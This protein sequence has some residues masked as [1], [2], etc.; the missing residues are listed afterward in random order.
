MPARERRAVLD[1]V[2]E[3][4]LDT[5]LVESL[6]VSIGSRWRCSTLARPELQYLA[7]VTVTHRSGFVIRTDHVEVALLQDLLEHVLDGLLGCPSSGR[8]GLAVV[9]A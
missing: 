7:L 9:R 2:A 8:L 1:N 5:G 3:C 4:P 6:E